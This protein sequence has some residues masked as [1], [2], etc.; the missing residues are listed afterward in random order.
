M[1][2]E[3]GRWP[4]SRWTS[5]DIDWK[6]AR[7]ITAGIDIGAVSSQA[8][9]ICDGQVY[10]YSNQRTGPSSK[11]SAR[12]AM[13]SALEGTGMGLKNIRETV[14]TGYGSSGADFANKSVNETVCHAKGARFM[15]GPTA[16]TVFDIGGQ[17]CKA[18]KLYEWDTIVDVAVN[19][20]CAVNMGWGIEMLADLMHVPITEMG[21]KSLNVKQEPEPVST[22][23]YVFANTEAVGLLRAGG[24]ENE[25]LG[26]YLF[27]ISWRLQGLLGRINPEKE[28]A[29]TGG[30]A[31][32]PGI[33]KR[34]EREMGITA[35]SSK[36]DPQLAGAIGAA[37]MAAEPA[38]ATSKRAVKSGV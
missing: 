37:I 11:A 30:L 25:A 33:V 24:G 8:V 18:I 23:C 34:L 26:A 27:A 10:A 38:K 4:E 17:T 22:T 20:K 6:K 36:Y 15:F 32:N 28:Y 35:L 14:A 9:I 29:F 3:Y 2:T 21:E 31:K 12:K 1:T 13:E 5:R 19:D 16:K 7:D